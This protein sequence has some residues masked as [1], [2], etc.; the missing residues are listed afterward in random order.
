MPKTKK[1]IAKSALP[2]GSLA[3]ASINGNPQSRKLNLFIVSSDKPKK[4]YNS[5]VIN[6]LYMYIK[7]KHLL[8]LTTIFTFFILFIILKRY[9]FNCFKFWFDFRIVG[10]SFCWSAD[11]LIF[12]SF[13]SLDFDLVIIFMLFSFSLSFQRKQQIS[14]EKKDGRKLN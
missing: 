9:V 14:G 12:V 5:I 13:L 4:T 6:S 7:N 3:E 8:A 1:Q 11:L 2:R 10:C